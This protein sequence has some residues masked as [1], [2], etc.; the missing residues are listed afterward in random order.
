MAKNSKTEVAQ[1]KADGSIK[2]YLNDELFDTTKRRPAWYTSLPFS[3]AALVIMLS[4]DITG[5]YQTMEALSGSYIVNKIIIV[6]ALGVAFEGA[7]LYV[8]YVLCVKSYG[9]EKPIHKYVFWL[10][11]I[12]CVLGVAANITFRFLL[13]TDQGDELL[14]LPFTIIMCVF[15]IITSLVNLVIGCLSFDPVLSEM[16]HMSKRLG[17]LYYKRRKLIKCIDELN[18]N[19]SSNNRLTETEDICYTG[20]KK[21]IV[22][23]QASFYS[24]I[25][26]QLCKNSSKNNRED[27]NLK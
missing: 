15:P 12:A 4:I 13:L 6:S 26:I 18:N 22:A 19:I 9:I 25:D 23:M 3:I 16:Q 24:Y 2:F 17:K 27:I 7:P 20:V 14:T 1:V 10:A 11:L 21:E 5:F 8:G